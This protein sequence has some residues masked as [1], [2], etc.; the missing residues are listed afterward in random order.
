MSLKEDILSSC[1]I[2]QGSGWVDSSAC[3]CL[4]KFRVYN[5]LL[6]SGFSRFLIEF[7]DNSS[8]QIPDIVLGQEFID[9]FLKNANY[10]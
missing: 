10:W 3:E 9:F 7:V 2:C 5:R 8:Y 6:N 4:L 1:S